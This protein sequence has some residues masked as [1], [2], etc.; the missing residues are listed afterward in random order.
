MHGTAHTTTTTKR[1]RRFVVGASS[2]ALLV[3]GAL[4][5]SGCGSSIKNETGGITNAKEFLT[6]VTQEWKASLP[7]AN[8]TTSEK[9]GC[10]YILGKDDYVTGAIACGGARRA[11]AGEGQVWDTYSF[12]V[13]EDGDGKQ[14]ATNAEPSETGMER[15]P[16]KLVNADG[17]EAP[18][19]ADK[20]KAPPLPK[21]ASGLIVN[22]A[23]AELT[24]EDSVAPGDA[25]RVITPGGTVT[26]TA[27]ATA[28][29]LATEGLDDEDPEGSPPL[30][31]PATGETFRVIDFSYVGSENPDAPPMTL[32]LSSSGKRTQVTELAA[33]GGWGGPEKG[34]QRILVSVPTDGDAELLVSAAG[35]DQVVELATGKRKADPGTDTF[36][37]RVTRQDLNKPLDFGSRAV[38]IDKYADDEEVTTALT[39]RSAELTPY[40]AGEKGWAAPGKAWLLVTLTNSAEMSCCG[41]VEGGTVTVKAAGKT[42][43]GTTKA[44]WE[45]S[46][47]STIYAA[48][49]VPADMTA[50]SLT[51]SQRVEVQAYG[52]DQPVFADFG[53]KTVDVAFPN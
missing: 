10:Y 23:P 42:I 49:E 4:T 13:L 41:G 6:A 5:L 24:L 19:E 11:G 39:V 26:I 40:V 25:G 21:A 47:D 48:I 12:T 45:D 9:P 16:G 35:H 15:P 14:S 2:A 33:S 27:V 51:I 31:G 46:Y 8:I 52:N 37:R 36:Y 28:P 18:Q 44:T 30:L 20:L 7:T 29:S 3:G 17:D 22:E 32:T 50:A 53:S 34:E 43:A 1:T 38:N